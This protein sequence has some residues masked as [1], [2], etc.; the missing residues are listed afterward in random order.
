MKQSVYK[1][2]AARDAFRAHYNH[3]L[4]RFPFEQNYINTDSTGLSARITTGVYLQ[5][6]TISFLFSML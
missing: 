5:N 1:T 6:F 3:V 4:C 2:E